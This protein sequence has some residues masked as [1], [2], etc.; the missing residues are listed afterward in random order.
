MAFE[1]EDLPPNVYV[2]IDEMILLDNKTQEPICHQKLI[3]KNI[4]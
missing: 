1:V 4:A 3:I 2:G